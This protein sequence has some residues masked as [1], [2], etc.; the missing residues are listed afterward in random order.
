MENPNPAQESSKR[1]DY[2]TKVLPV[3]FNYAGSVSVD[4]V[5]KQVVTWPSLAKKMEP[6]DIL[7]LE[8]KEYED[9]QGTS[10]KVENGLFPLYEVVNGHAK[11]FYSRPELFMVTKKPGNV[12]DVVELAEEAPNPKV[13]HVVVNAHVKKGDDDGLAKLVDRYHQNAK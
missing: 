7:Q 1:R 8:V 3:T 2:G 6:G 4:A 9:E 13:Y 5:L 11:I 10:H 12:G